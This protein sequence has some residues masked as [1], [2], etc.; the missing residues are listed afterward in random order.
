M[1]FGA[2]GPNITTSGG[3]YSFEQALLAA[4]LM[5]DQPTGPAL[6]L[7]AEEGHETFSPLLD[8]SID[9]GAGL[10]D[11]GGALCVNSDSKGSLCRISLPFY[12]SCQAEKVIVSLV[13]SLGI[14]AEP[15]DYC[16]ILVGIPAAMHSQGAKQLEQFKVLMQT[17]API[18]QYRKFTGEFA[19]ASAVAAALAASF[20]A[21]GRIPGSLTGRDDIAVTE[22]C[23]KILVVGLGQYIT[24]MELCRT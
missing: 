4:Q 7:G 19:C 23:N 17:S 16:L 13:D 5:V 24:A 3:D 15:Q 2:T 14:T 20:F 10:A 22:S 18:V 11:G 12:Q 1:M 8:A 9:Y 6:I 21:S